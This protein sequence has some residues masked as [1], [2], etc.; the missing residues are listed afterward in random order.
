MKAIITIDI[1][2]EGPQ[3]SG[4]TRAIDLIAANLMF[5]GNITSLHLDEESAPN[6]ATARI[7][8]EY[9]PA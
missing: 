9:T 3:G 2:A 7:V 5:L 4:K 6:V 1:K 8:L